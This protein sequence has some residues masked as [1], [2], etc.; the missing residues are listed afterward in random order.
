MSRK[1]ILVTGGAGFV[2]SHT[3]DALLRE[4]HQVRVFDS[5]E[6]QVHR[7][8]VPDY[9]SRDAELVRGDVRDTE[10]L[11]R[12]LN[13]IDVIYHFAAAV[14]VGQSMYE[15]ARYIEMNTQ[16]TAN[17]LQ[18]LLDRRDKT[19]KLIVASSMSIYGEGQYLCREHGT[20]AAEPRTAEQLR[21]REWHAGCP[22]CNRALQPL[23]TTESK[24][25]QCSSIYAL[26]KKDQE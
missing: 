2:G 26:S 16:G 25:A 15:I 13:G 14:G 24:P 22:Q 4:G 10:A 21:A 9:L 6:E 12:A 5:L 17:L 23:A 19:E 1:R 11:R 3:V 7:G 20:V 18:L 8:H